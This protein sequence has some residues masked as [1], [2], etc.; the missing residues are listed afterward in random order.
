MEIFL[1]VLVQASLHLNKPSE[2]MWSIVPSI[3]KDKPKKKPVII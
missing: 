2:I 1:A 3:K